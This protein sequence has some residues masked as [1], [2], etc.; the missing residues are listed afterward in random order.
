MRRRIGSAGPQAGPATHAKFTT[1]L[2]GAAAY[3]RQAGA[4]KTA[5]NKVVDRERLPIRARARPSMSQLQILPSMES[6]VASP[7]WQAFSRPSGAA[8]VAGER[9]SSGLWLGV[10]GPISSDT[11]W[12]F[13]VGLP[14]LFV[15]TWGLNLYGHLDEA[16]FRKSCLSCCC[17]QGLRCS[18]LPL[19]RLFAQACDAQ[20]STIETE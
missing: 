12:F 4:H 11:I 5:L 7:D 19:P 6:T 15:E 18:C 10:N 20:A 3:S 17:F 14:V 9:I 16:G 8:C 2:R 13:V 1:V